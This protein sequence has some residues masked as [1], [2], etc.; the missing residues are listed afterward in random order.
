M[1]RPDQRIY[2]S[3]AYLF[4]LARLLDQGLYAGRHVIRFNDFADF[5][6]QIKDRLPVIDRHYVLEALIREELRML[7][8]PEEEILD[9]T[10][11]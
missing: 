5:L 4:T 2:V 8:T 7:E 9:V 3:A 10:T 1:T 6:N 11:P